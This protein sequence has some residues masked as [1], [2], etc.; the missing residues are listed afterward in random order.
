[1]PPPIPLS[2]S[3]G[4]HNKFSN[5]ASLFCLLSTLLVFGLSW[6]FGTVSHNLTGRNLVLATLAYDAVSCLLVAVGLIMG[7]LALLMMKPGGRGKV[8]FR[9]LAGVAMAGLFLAI[10]VPNFIQ[11]RA[12]TLAQR[13]A[14][15]NVI[16]A[17]KNLKPQETAALQTNGKS[18]S[19]K[20]FTQTQ[21][22]AAK[23]TTTAEEALVKQGSEAYTLRAQAV[24]KAYLQ[25]LSNLTAAQVLGTSNV[26][27]REILQQRRE[28]VQN[29]LKFNANFRNFME[30]GE[31]N[32]RAE[33][34]RLNISPS[35]IDEAVTEFHKSSSPQLPL[36]TDIRAQNDRMGRGMLA[37]LDLLDINWG[38]WSYDE[39]TGHIRFENG[40]LVE[41]YNTD[42]KGINEAVKAETLSQKRLVTVMSQPTLQ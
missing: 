35:I 38:H 13:D 3:N 20:Q 15:L 37:V 7:I 11:A 24:Q 25:A 29:F 33:L 19:L 22:Q 31:D 30:G 39:S 2:A 41:Q 17:G 8:V 5:S 12:R 18:V 14:P 40:E 27:S 42:L 21:N 32:F 16:A 1:M 36:F 10:F 4:E 9:S 28:V 34:V 6:A 23:T 26:V